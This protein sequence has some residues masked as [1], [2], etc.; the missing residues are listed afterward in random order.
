MGYGDSYGIVFDIEMDPERG[1]AAV[2]VGPYTHKESS[3]GWGDGRLAS[4][5]GRCCMVNPPHCPS[6]T[7]GHPLLPAH[8]Y[9]SPD[10]RSCR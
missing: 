5:G 7:A 2:G 4:R 3:G 10:C 6:S 9:P 1:Y 8:C